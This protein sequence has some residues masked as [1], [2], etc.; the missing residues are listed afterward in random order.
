MARRSRME[1]GGAE[2]FV[3]VAEEH[4]YGQVHLVLTEPVAGRPSYFDTT[5]LRVFCP[6]NVV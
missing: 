5:H 4:R 6:L 3:R 1:A 2:R